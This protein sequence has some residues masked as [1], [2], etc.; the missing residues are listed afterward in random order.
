MIYHNGTT[1][2]ILS[3]S[4]LIVIT[5]IFLSSI[6]YKNSLT[7]SK[8]LRHIREKIKQIKTGSIISIF[9]LLGIALH[10]FMKIILLDTD[11]ELYDLVN[12]IFQV[13]MTIII[14]CTLLFMLVQTYLNFRKD[15]ND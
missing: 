8:G 7:G 1:Q 13:A 10:F 3:I 11:L 9:L 12:S 5:I 15:K 2:I 6:L 14:L 4:L